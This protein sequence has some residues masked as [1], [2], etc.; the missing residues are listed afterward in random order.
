MEL[1]IGIVSA[2]LLVFIIIAIIVFRNIH[3]RGDYDDDG[4]IQVGGEGKQLF[5]GDEKEIAGAEGERYVNYHLRPLLRNDEYL[6]ANVL[7]PLKNGHTK[8][9]DCIL[10]TRKGVFCIETKYWVGYIKGN[11]ED[12]YW[13]QEYDDPGKD[14]N[15]LKNP[16]KQNKFHCDVLNELLLNRFPIENVVVFAELEYGGDIN[17][18]YVFTINQFKKYYRSLDDNKIE[19]FNLNVIYQQLARYVATD[20]ELEKHKIDTCRRVNKNKTVIK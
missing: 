13:I 20:E 1:V 14:D 10:I 15:R 4:G 3:N 5:S 11:D 12:D 17:S 19:V 18:N 2:L 9:I 6:L 16:V 8:E 7:L